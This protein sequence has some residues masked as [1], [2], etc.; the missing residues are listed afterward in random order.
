LDKSEKERSTF[1]NL[2]GKKDIGSADSCKKVQLGCLWF[3]K[4]EP[5]QKEPTHNLKAYIIQEVSFFLGP[6]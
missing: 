5:D 3:F 1:V 4:K 2:S 6:L